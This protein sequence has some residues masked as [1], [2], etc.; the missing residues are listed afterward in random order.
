[1]R[2]E[3][4]HLWDDD[5]LTWVSWNHRDWKLAGFS[6]LLLPPVFTICCPTKGEIKW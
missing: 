2:R 4:A 3:P 5:E 6:F 1:M